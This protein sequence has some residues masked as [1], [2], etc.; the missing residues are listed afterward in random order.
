M[1][2]IMFQTFFG[3]VDACWRQEINNRHLPLIFICNDYNKV[4]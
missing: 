4:S 3:D 2:Q 1:L